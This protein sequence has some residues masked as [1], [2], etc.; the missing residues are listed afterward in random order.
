MDYEKDDKQRLLG[1]ISSL[2][3]EIEGLKEDIEM[4]LQEI[5]EAESE[6]EELEELEMVSRKPKVYKV[7]K[8]TGTTLSVYIQLRDVI[9][10]SATQ[11]ISNLQGL[12]EEFSKIKE[13]DYEYIGDPKMHFSETYSGYECWICQEYYT[14]SEE[15]WKERVRAEELALM[16][17]EMEKAEKDESKAMQRK[18]E[19][20]EALMRIESELEG[21]SEQGCE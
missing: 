15:D 10:G 4:K 12:F 3:D 2:E 17:W 6:L 5:E 9:S 18:K 20:Q 8:K 16:K 1:Y 13:K 7:R 19:L 11:V 21:L 14:E